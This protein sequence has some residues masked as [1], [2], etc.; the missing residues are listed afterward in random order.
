V[1][2]IV[3][4]MVVRLETIQHVEELPLYARQIQ[5]LE[6]LQIYAPMGHAVGVGSLAGKLEDLCFKV[7]LIAPSRPSSLILSSSSLINFEYKANDSHIQ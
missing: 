7:F 4:E 6:C 1:R 2:A 3:V 5:A